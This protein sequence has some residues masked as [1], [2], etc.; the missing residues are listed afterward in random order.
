MDGLEQLADSPWLF[1]LMAVL[2]AFDAVFPPVPSD[3]IMTAIVALSASR[4]TPGLL[5]VVP[6]TGLGAFVGDALCYGVGRAGAPAALRRWEHR[7][8]VAKSYQ[9]AE[10]NISRRGWLFILTARYIP[11]GRCTTM[12][13][14]GALK[15][16][17]ARFCALDAISVSIAVTIGAAVGYTGGVLFVDAPFI[18]MA[19]AVVIITSLSVVRGAAAVW[20][21]LRERGLAAAPALET[22]EDSAVQGDPTPTDPTPKQPVSAECS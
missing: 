16:S 22:L 12:L 10:R 6:A 7:P 9:W 18:G 20:R 15:Y 3:E 14:C 8:A 19:F 2:A 1:P 11:F 21:R 17:F 5:W 4:N 13:A